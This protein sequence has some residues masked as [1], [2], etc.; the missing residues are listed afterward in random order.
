MLTSSLNTWPCRSH[1][2][3]TRYI[4]TSGETCSN[5]TD[6]WVSKK[7]GEVSAVHCES[8]V[9]HQTA[10]CGY[11]QKQLTLAIL[12][13]RISSLFSSITRRQGWRK[14]CWILHHYHHRH[15]IFF[16]RWCV[17]C[18]YR[19]RE[20]SLAVYN[21][22][23]ESR[24]SPLLSTLSLLHWM[25]GCGSLWVILYDMSCRRHIYDI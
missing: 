9:S 13:Y 8:F 17:M 21:E 11:K 23:V 2:R 1:Q 19:L 14:I 6:S 18:F 10:A 22:C 7:H 15:Q 16:S 25:R 3:K 12:E 5:A 4:S 20:W 24:M